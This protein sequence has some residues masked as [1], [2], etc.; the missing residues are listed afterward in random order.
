MQMYGKLYTFWLDMTLNRR[1]DKNSRIFECGSE[2]I[3]IRSKAK[4]IFVL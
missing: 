3:P 2:I 1:G 4:N